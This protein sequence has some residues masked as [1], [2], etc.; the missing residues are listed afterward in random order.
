MATK[1]IGTGGDYSTIQA[2]E[3]SLAATLTSPEVGQLKNESFSG[4]A[5]FSGTTTSSSNTITL[6]CV[7]GASFRDNANA[8]TNAL[9]PNASYGAIITN[10]SNYDNC[11]A[12]SESYVIIRYIQILKTGAPSKAINVSGGAT[13]NVTID[14]CLIQSKPGSSSGVVEVVGASSVVKN[15]CIINANTSGYGV[16]GQS[17]SS[18]INANT[19]V[20]P[21]VNSP[22][23]TGIKGTY[24]TPLATD[25]AVFGFTTS[26]SGDNSSSDYNAS[27]TTL[28][29][30]SH[31]QASKTFSNQFVDTGSTLANSD[32]RLKAG[33]DCI[34]TG[35]S[36]SMPTTDII[37]QARGASYDIGCW[38]VQSAAARI[39]TLMLLGVG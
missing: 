12:V 32:F 26:M 2:W 5:T 23:G 30:G 9:Y 27:D 28:P 6:E 14:S 7:T 10:S 18:A 4:N 17:G 38:E 37:G 36:A 8:A 39:S 11:I 25:N 33:A 20:R 16:Q 1:T 3:D 21:A 35:T 34:D 22:A 24:A 29:H 13:D 19:I 31:N 15:C